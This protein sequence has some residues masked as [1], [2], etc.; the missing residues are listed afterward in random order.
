[1]RALGAQLGTGI[2]HKH[3]DRVFEH[4]DILNHAAKRSTGDDLLLEGKVSGNLLT[5]AGATIFGQTEVTGNLS[6]KANG[7]VTQNGIINVAGSTTIDAFNQSIAL[8]QANDFG[9]SVTLNGTDI[10][11]SDRNSL[12]VMLSANNG[13]IQAGDDL[14][15]QG[16]VFGN[17]ST[18][19]GATIFGQTNVAGDLS[20]KS[21]GP[22][23]HNSKLN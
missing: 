19:A 7:P 1:M 13:I 17:L 22:V 4:I 12:T 8:S 21:N 2:R 16:K 20:V 3:A 10:S 15:L 14:S 11:I 23:M 9:G 6:V 5:V 18:F